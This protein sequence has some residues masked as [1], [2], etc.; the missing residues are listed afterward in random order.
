MSNAKDP[1]CS[2]CHDLIP[3]GEAFDIPTDGGWR[4]L[5]PTCHYESRL[6]GDPVIDP[7]F[8]CNESTAF[9]S[10]KFVNRIGY[11]DGWACAECS[12][13]ECD[14]CDKV[15]YLDTDVSDEH[16][17]GHYHTWCLT[18]DKWDECSR[19]WLFSLPLYEQV[20]VLTAPQEVQ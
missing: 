18:P 16:E 2:S 13:Y 9:G 5:C 4:P 20:T 8:H 15:I 19:E 17:W 11:D 7:C 3:E 14:K 10:G 1:Y 12:G 6:N